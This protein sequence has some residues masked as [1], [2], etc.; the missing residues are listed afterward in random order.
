MSNTLALGIPF[1]WEWVVILVVGLLI[2]GRRMPDI[3]RSVGKSIVEFKKG[4]KDVKGEIDMAA[5][6]PAEPSKLPPHEPPEQ[7]KT[8][9]DQAKSATSEPGPSTS[10]E[11]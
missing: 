8:Q 7:P 11:V 9:L 5:A 3:A 10:Q 6:P 2:F 1:G 4:L